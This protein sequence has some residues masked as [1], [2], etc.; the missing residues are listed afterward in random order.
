MDIFNVM[1]LWYL[2]LRSLGVHWNKTTRKAFFNSLARR[3]LVLMLR[4]KYTF[5]M[6]RWETINHTT[7]LTSPSA[8]PAVV[9]GTLYRTHLPC[10]IDHLTWA[11]PETINILNSV[12]DRTTMCFPDHLLRPCRIFHPL[13]EPIFYSVKASSFLIH[14]NCKV[15]NQ[16]LRPWSRLNFLVASKHSV[17]WYDPFT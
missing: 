3:F 14:W 5:L 7:A 2:Y 13:S 15:N 12:P 4:W 10:R 1:A 16:W 17:V 8:S 9:C 11:N 6:P